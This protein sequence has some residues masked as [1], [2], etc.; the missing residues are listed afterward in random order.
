MGLAAYLTYF[1]FS[2]A[3][4]DDWEIDEEAMFEDD[5]DDDDAWDY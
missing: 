4:D 1:E 3:F 2:S 5:V